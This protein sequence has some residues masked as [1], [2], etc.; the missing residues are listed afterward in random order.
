MDIYGVNIPIPEQPL[1]PSTSP[2]GLAPGMAERLAK[3]RA[4]DTARVTAELGAKGVNPGIPTPSTTSTNP[5]SLWSKAGRTFGRIKTSPKLGGVGLGLGSAA[6]SAALTP[7]I[8]KSEEGGPQAKFL[9]SK[10][11]ADQVAGGAALG[12]TVSPTPYAKALLLAPVASALGKRLGYMAGGG[13]SPEKEARDIAAYKA[14]TAKYLKPQTEYNPSYPALDL[15]H[16]V[17]RGEVKPPVVGNAGVPKVVTPLA[18]EYEPQAYNPR[19]ENA[20]QALHNKSDRSLGEAQNL[21]QQR[22]DAELNNIGTSPLAALGS[23][24]G[25]VNAASNLTDV[26]GARSKGALDTMHPMN[27][28]IAQGQLLPNEL[29]ASKMKDVSTSKQH[30]ADPMFGQ[31]MALG[32]LQLDK[33]G[34]EIEGMDTQELVRMMGAM[35]KQHP[36]A[37]LGE[38]HGAMETINK[39]R[40]SQQMAPDEE[41]KAAIGADIQNLMNQIKKVKVR[42][43]S[44]TTSALPAIQ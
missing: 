26:M 24:A 34:K 41:T 22:L 9:G 2:S 4:T 15:Y 30:L 32:K 18:P 13:V 21:N 42:G 35:D 19:A 11:T 17:E 8:A 44:N 27:A 25:S 1:N 7:N 36:Q 33:I 12:G 16:G 23:Y 40:Q 28:A 14:A 5:N 38:Y 6:L 29:A 39:M 10:L 43:G 20:I 37:T 3:Q 31:K